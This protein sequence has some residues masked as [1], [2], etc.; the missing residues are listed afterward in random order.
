MIHELQHGQHPSF[1][2]VR[3]CRGALVEAGPDVLS[4]S[5]L[6]ETLPEPVEDLEPNAPKFGWQPTGSAVLPG[7]CVA[8]HGGPGARSGW[9]Q[10]P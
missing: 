9:L 1:T 2:A 7:L 8:V 10:R 3:E 4:W 5:D 6:S